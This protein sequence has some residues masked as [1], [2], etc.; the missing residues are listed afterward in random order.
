MSECIIKAKY[1]SKHIKLTVAHIYAPTV[2]ADEEVK[3]ELYLKIQGVLDNRNMH[4]MLLVIGDMNAKVGDYNRNYERITGKLGLG[5]RNDNGDRMCRLWDMNE[6][7]MTGTPFPHKN[8]HKETWV[9]PDRAT[10]I[11]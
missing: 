9:A 5:V 7:V 8:L 6:I 2:D 4:D 3:D 1:F 10:R 11:T